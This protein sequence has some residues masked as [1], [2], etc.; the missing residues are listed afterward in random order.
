IEVLANSLD[1]PGRAGRVVAVVGGSGGAGASS[2]AGA[3]AMIAARRGQDTL[4]V[5]AD[6]LGGG[7][8]ML[9][10][11]ED[12]EG[13][14]WPD[15]AGTSGRIDARSLRQALPRVG[16]LSMLSWDRGDVWSAPVDSMRSVLAAGQRANDLVVVDLP[17]LLDGTAEETLTFA[18]IALL[19]VRA[20]IRAVAA[21]GRVL[22]RLRD[23][24]AQVELVVRGPGPTGMDADIVSDALRLPL[25]ARIRNDARVVRSIDD[26]LGPLPRKKGGLAGAA[27]QV[28]DRLSAISR[29]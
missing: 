15:L 24:T 6:P 11:A 3:L 21:A 18:D 5:D 16:G 2:F 26:G 8:D 22:E 19:V 10:G 1:H 7:I 25:C 12:I 29:P 14:R 9:L 17:R 4:V 27:H 20:E 23:R 13:L 28:V